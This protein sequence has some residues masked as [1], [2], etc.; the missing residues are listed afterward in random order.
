MKK[1]GI[2]KIIFLILIFSF[3]LLAQ[4]NKIGLDRIDAMVGRSST[5]DM[6]RFLMEQTAGTGVVDIKIWAW[7]GSINPDPIFDRKPRE[8]EGYKVVPGIRMSGWH[9]YR[10]A[11]LDSAVAEA[12]AHGLSVALAI[13]GPPRW[14]RG[15]VCDYDLG[16]Y[17]SCGLIE[18]SHFDIFRNALFDFS[19]YLAERY[20]DIKYFIAYNE[21][22]LSYAFAVE[23]PYLGGSLLN[24]YI[25]LVY[26]PIADG[27]RSSGR[28]VY[29]VGPEITLQDVNNE[30]GSTKW[31]EDWI[32]PILENYP[33]YFDVIGIHSYTVDANQTLEKMEKLRK[34]LKQFS[35]ATQRVWITEFNFGTD[36]EPLTRRDSNIFLQLL[37]L[38]SNQWWERSYF[39][40]MMDSLIY[41]DEEYFGQRKPLYDLFKLLVQYFN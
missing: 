39:F 26:W 38:F 18:K 14:P 19:Y 4:E 15:N 23:K 27:V 9:R 41:T 11:Y 8:L 2:I 28:E 29:I 20:P 3:S 10:F 25:D 32:L 35:Y 6:P 37:V 12:R 31:L 33:N 13:H 36:K 5:G 1:N 21:P 16:T 24:S 7:W 22:N 40:T 30:L 17:H 34:A